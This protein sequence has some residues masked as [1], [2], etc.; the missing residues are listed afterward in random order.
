[1]FDDEEK[2]N[3]LYTI[4]T[5]QDEDDQL[6]YQE[7]LLKCKSPKQ[8]DHVN[9]MMDMKQSLL[10]PNEMIQFPVS[11]GIT[12]EVYKKQKTIFFNDFTTNNIMYVS[13]IDN[14]KSIERI[15]NILVGAVQRDNGTT[16]GI[17]QLFNSPKPITPETRKKFKAA[18]RFIGQCI[19][20]VEDLTKKLT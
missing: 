16:T 6:K 5:G 14:I 4:T 20:N 11:S 15:S 17:I 3:T 1:M 18:S 2:K 19:Q 7:A 12:S 9:A 13:E 10:S 8:I